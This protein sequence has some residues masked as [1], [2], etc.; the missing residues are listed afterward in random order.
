MSYLTT[1]D[2]TNEKI[3]SRKVYF[4]KMYTSLGFCYRRKHTLKTTHFV[5]VD[6]ATADAYVD[7]HGDDEYIKEIYAERDG[8]A[9]YYRVV[10][11]T[12]QYPDLWTEFEPWKTAPAPTS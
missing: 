1:C 12:D 10:V 8:E 5:G 4:E 11:N 9:G 3:I 6:K 2:S 7:D